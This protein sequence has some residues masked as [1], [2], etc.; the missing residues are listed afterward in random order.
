MDFYV[1]QIVNGVSVDD[2]AKQIDASNEGS[3]FDQEVRDL[4]SESVGRINK[5]NFNQ[6]Y[7]A[8]IDSGY[9]KEQFFDAIGAELVT[10]AAGKTAVSFVPNQPLTQGQQ[11]LDAIKSIYQQEFGRAPDQ[12]GLVFY[13]QK[14]ESGTPLAQVRSEIKAS[15][16][17]RLFDETLG[18]QVAKQ[19]GAITGDNL[20]KIVNDLQ[21]QGYSFEQV[22][23]AIGG[24][25][26]TNEKGESVL[27]Y[28]P[29][30]K[31]FTNDEIQ[32][33]ITDQFGSVTPENF[34]Q[35]VNAVVGAGVPVD[36]LANVIDATIGT[37]DKGD[38]TLS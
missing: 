21:K 6:A 4:V 31:T 2:I 35:V 38:T 9:T 32:R 19:Y 8:A 26:S 18:K 1:Q 16:E 24:T 13:L 7:E 25:I 14:L 34:Q 29:P 15:E 30:T 20:N 12:E 11:N 22:A 17:A 33:L 36:Q 27:S 3:G 10:D 23:D 37:D 28:T 5:D